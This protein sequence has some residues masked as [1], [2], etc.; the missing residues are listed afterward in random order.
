MIL[1]VLSSGWSQ[2]L[3]LRMPSLG[4]GAQAP[5]RQFKLEPW[6]RSPKSNI[7]SLGLGPKPEMDLLSLIL[8]AKLEIDN[9][10]LEAKP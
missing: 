9:S 8:P 10:S 1:G 2:S 6:I 3:E 5:S 7:L 4:L